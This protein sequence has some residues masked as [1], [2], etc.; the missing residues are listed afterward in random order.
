MRLLLLHE[1]TRRPLHEFTL[2]EDQELSAD[3]ILEYDGKHWVYHDA[4][5]D[6]DGNYEEWIPAEVVSLNVMLQRKEEG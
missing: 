1:N 4:G 6:E 2:S 5:G 3:T